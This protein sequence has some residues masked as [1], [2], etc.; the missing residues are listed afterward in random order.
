[1]N[2]YV[3][4]SV[5]SNFS[6][7]RGASHAEELV[8]RAKRLELAGI[9]ITDHNSVAG[10]VR[11]HMAAKEAQLP[12]APGCRLVFMDDTPDVFVWPES[13]I[14]WGNLCELLSYGKRKAPKGECHLSLEDLLEYGSGLVMA[15]HPNV[16]KRK[17]SG[18]QIQKL[19]DTFGDYVYL[20]LTRPYGV[21]DQREM[22]RVSRL[23]DQ[24]GV[25]LVALGDVLY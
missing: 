16:G 19:K 2:N 1:M 6:F 12:F 3:E 17:A 21:S 8:V 23:S 4:L 15:I 18:A 11:G 24:Y 7:L 9:S 10:L 25:P 5:A 20:G 22:V 14:A 13:R